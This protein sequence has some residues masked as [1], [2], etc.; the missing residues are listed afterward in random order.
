M[1]RMNQTLKKQLI[2]PNLETKLPWTKYLPIVL[3]RI[4]MAPRKD[5][6]LSSYEMLYGLLYLGRTVDL[7][8]TE[9]KDKFLRKYILATSS[10]LS[11][12]RLKGLLA[13]SPHSSICS[14][15]LPA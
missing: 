2:K 7:P 6:G 5:V 11:S 3:L 10:T 4:R 15:S 9:I 12:L 8:T 1:E 14:S 13:Q